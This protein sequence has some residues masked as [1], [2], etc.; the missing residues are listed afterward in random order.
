MFV[1][2]ATNNIM[3]CHTPYPLT[4]IYFFSFQKTILKF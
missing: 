3:A 4:S 2:K 1:I